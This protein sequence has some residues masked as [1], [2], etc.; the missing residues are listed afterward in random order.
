MRDALSLLDQA[1]AHG[2]GR[3]EETSV[4]EMLG[5][6]DRGYLFSILNALIR[7]HGPALLAEADRMGARSLSF[8]TALQ[9]L[10]TLLHRIALAQTV[11]GALA[12]DEPEPKPL[13]A[14]VPSSS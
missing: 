5:A 4:R 7:G 6:V 11:P 14:L 13:M 9:D 10:A 12:E 8:E 3:V 2:G 1:I